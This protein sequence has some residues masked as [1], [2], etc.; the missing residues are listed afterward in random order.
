MSPSP[1]RAAGCVVWRA[2]REET[3]LLLVHRPRYD[4]W[5]FPKG[6]LDRGESDR[7]AAL[8]EVK[9]E[10]GLSVALGPRLPDQCYP[11]SGGQQKVVTYWAAKPL[12]D[13]D[14]STYSL[15][16][17]VDQLGWLPLAEARRRLSYQ[18]DR[19]QLDA[20]QRAAYD[21]A[22]LLVVRHAHARSRKAWRSD[23]RERPLDSRGTRE[24]EALRE[25]LS[26]YG[27]AH[28]ISSDARRCVDSVLP[29]VNASH[30]EL[31]LDPVLSEAGMQPEPLAR[32]VQDAL[33]RDERVALCSHRPLLFDI[34][35]AADV[36]PIGLEPAGVVVIH[37]RNGKLL[38]VEQLSC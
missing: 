18:R 7:A 28:V 35:D 29:Y 14:V 19:K 1:V 20:F 12:T 36:D 25:V 34:F 16:D 21:S 15:N 11:V 31:R 6:K 24:A 9:E 13:G 26:E 3:E 30:A 23:D 17:E 32:L 37:R 27:V 8:R 38:D 33:H 22:P 5:S 10:T 2:C 4:D